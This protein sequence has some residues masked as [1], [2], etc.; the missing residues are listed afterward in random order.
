MTKQLNIFDQHRK[1]RYKIFKE[2]F[3]KGVKE[4]YENKK[5]DVYTHISISGVSQEEFF[6]QINLIPKKR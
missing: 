1:D 6:K 5:H 2:N 4:R 3:Y